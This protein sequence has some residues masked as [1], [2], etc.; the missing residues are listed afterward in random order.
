MIIGFSNGNGNGNGN[1]HSRSERRSLWS[2][3]RRAEPDLAAYRRLALQLHFDLSGPD[4]H[5]AALLVAPGDPRHCPVAG[6]S[7]ARCLGEQLRRPVLLIDACR[8]ARETSMLMNCAAARGFGEILTDPTLAIEEL[9]VPTTIEQVRFLPAGAAATSASP[10]HL[11]A[12]LECA[13]RKFDFVLL[14][15]GNFLEDPVL[16]TLASLVGCVLLLVA[17]AETRI[18]DLDAAQNTLRICGV[19]KTGLL[20]AASGNGGR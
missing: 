15:G 6:T 14:S 12:V 7:L 3:R 18:D 13:R 4:D 9:A 16:L 8:R 10:Q 11:C 2:A 1:G 19:R 17:E 20:W 5:R